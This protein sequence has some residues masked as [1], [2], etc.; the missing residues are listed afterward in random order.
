MPYHTGTMSTI[1]AGGAA[2]QYRNIEFGGY[3]HSTGLSNLICASSTIY[4]W[5]D[6]NAN[7]DTYTSGTGAISLGTRG[8]VSPNNNFGVANPGARFVDNKF[9]GFIGSQLVS[10]SGNG[11]GTLF[12][13]NYT[14]QNN[15]M[16]FY[17]GIGNIDASASNTGTGYYARLI[18]IPQS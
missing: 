14:T 9:Y 4:T 18:Y 5:D 3:S 6:P 16:K 13:Y 12:Y 2:C 11:C 8:P 15:G 7:Y 10:T 1:R 17:S